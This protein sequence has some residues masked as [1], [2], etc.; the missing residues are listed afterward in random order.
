MEP[1]NYQERL[2]DFA[3]SHKAESLRDFL[4]T[5]EI[6]TS[7]AKEVLRERLE[8]YLAENRQGQLH[9]TQYLNGVDGWGN[10]HIYLYRANGQLTADWRNE[11][12][13]KTALRGGRA[14][15]LLNRPRS[16][17]LPDKPSL[18]S[19]GWSQAHLRLVWNEKRE[20]FERR[21][22]EDTEE[23][24]LVFR[25]WEHKISRGTLA[26]DWDLRTGHAMVMIQRLP[27][28]AQY[29]AVRDRVTELLRPFLDLS[30]FGRTRISP[31]IKAILDSGEVRERKTNWET[32]QG[33]RASFQSASRRQGVGSDQ[34]LKRMESEGRADLQGSLGNMYWLPTAGGE[35]ADELHT[36]LHK[37]D[38]R[39]AIMGER[40]EQEVRYVINRI[41]A[42]CN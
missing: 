16:V 14:L 34:T 21:E 26:F 23:D 4:R 1:N 20:W 9:L 6:P 2:L 8:T 12:T 7:G 33:G 30:A 32:T 37:N 5:Q 31:A 42:Y 18:A 3:L 10:Q 15:G 41:R 13:V 36:T 25:A 40:T 19:V 24:G 17:V 38:Q 11:E 35:L 27:R 28:G 29:A 39:V 22:D